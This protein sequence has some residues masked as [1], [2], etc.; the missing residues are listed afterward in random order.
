MQAAADMGAGLARAGIRLVYG[1]GHLGLM[2]AVAD[3]ALDAGGEVLGIIPQFL[4]EWEVAHDRV[5]NL[6]VTDSMHSR[7]RRMFEE[8]DAF[9]T[10]PGG[11]GTLDETVEIITWKQLRLHTKPVFICNVG[12]WADGLLGAFEKAVNDGFAAA[13][14]HRLYEVFPDV[15]SVLERLKTVPATVHAAAPQL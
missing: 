13:E 7:K 12:G 8:S 9:I 4:T 5:T 14:A 3:G 11:L 2:G 10:L 6:V 1:G 15:A